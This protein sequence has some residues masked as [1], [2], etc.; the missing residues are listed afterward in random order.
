MSGPGTAAPGPAPQSVRKHRAKQKKNVQK[1]AAP[2]PWQA[3]PAVQEPE[4]EGPEGPLGRVGAPG[5]RARNQT[6]MGFL[7]W[8]GI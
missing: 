3:A 2:W 8:E 4:Q 5:C 7:A 6:H 1:A